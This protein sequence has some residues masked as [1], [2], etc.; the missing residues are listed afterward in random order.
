MNPLLSPP[1][2]N[3]WSNR[4][5]VE[6]KTDTAFVFVNLVPFG[7][8]YPFL[9]HLSHFIF[10]LLDNS[11]L[12]NILS[13]PL[14]SLPFLSSLFKDHI[15]SLP[16]KWLTAVS[17]SSSPRSTRFRCFV[18]HKQLLFPFPSLLQTTNFPSPFPHTA[19]STP[20]LRNP[21][22]QL[23]TIAFIMAI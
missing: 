2:F 8:Y 17:S 7:I 6:S 19:P 15:E 20:S 9:H 13:S 22:E 11:L 1:V 4:T 16:K 18:G 21:H 10:S 12:Q 23:K 5:K 14:P 3:S